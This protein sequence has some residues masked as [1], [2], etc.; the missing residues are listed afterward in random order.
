MSATYIISMCHHP[1][2]I[3]LT[4]NDPP[5]PPAATSCQ[6]LWLEPHETLPSPD[7]GV[8]D[9]LVCAQVTGAAWIHA[10]NSH[11][12]SEDAIHSILPILY[13]FYTVSWG[14]SRRPLWGWDLNSL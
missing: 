13:S 8:T 7:A 12:M 10:C 1:V 11:V 3:P 2:A 5:S 4:K 6:W 9:W 14:G